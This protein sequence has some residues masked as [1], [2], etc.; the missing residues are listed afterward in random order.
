[1]IKAECYLDVGGG[2]CDRVVF[3]VEDD[4]GGKGKISFFLRP[5]GTELLPLTEGLVPFQPM[6]HPKVYPKEGAHA[7]CTRLHVGDPDCK[8]DSTSCP[9]CPDA[10][11][12]RG[13]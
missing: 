5:H 10:P 6:A 2:T 13:K 4:C 9:G 7:A 1:M 3:V 11:D 8:G 12:L